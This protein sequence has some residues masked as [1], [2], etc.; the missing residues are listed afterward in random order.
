MQT[1]EQ[2]LEMVECAEDNAFSEMLEMCLKR[3]SHKSLSA[4]CRAE[5]F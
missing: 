5:S 2:T 3:S 1:L 4:M